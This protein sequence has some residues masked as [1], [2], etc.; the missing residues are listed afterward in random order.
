MLTKRSLAR[1]LEELTRGDKD[2]A[3]ILEQYGTPPLWTREQGFPTL[4]LTILEQQVS[5]ASAGAA[6]K[7]LLAL[8]SPLTPE[9][10]L[11]FDDV[12]LKAAGF[13]RQKIIYG[14]NLAEAIC[15]GSLEL[16]AVGRME[17]QAAR[18]EL[19]KLKGIGPWT[20]EIYL[21]RALLRQDAWPGGDLALAVAVQEIKRLPDRPTPVELE[22]ISLRWRP[23]RAV[24]ARLLWNYYL[25]RP[26]RPKSLDQTARY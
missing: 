9:K 6:F 5:L 23:W 7:K 3:R 16:D 2:L 13:S 17:D 12:T 4:I 21:L 8:A 26:A 22:A 20:A 10:F 14:R 19:L 24:A 1:G 15:N 11:E 18:S 25:H